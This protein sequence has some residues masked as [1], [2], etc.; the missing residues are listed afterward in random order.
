MCCNIDVDKVLFS[1]S[2]HPSF[3]ARVAFLSTCLTL[4]SADHLSCNGHVCDDQRFSICVF[5]MCIGGDKNALVIR[6]VFFC[7]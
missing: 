5:L 7:Y 2:F 3:T 1:L 4:F 6:E